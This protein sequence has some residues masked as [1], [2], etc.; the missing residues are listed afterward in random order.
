MMSTGCQDHDQ[1][2]VSKD[3]VIRFIQD[4]MCKAGTTLEDA[5]AVGHHLMTA[6]YRGHFS[7]GMNRMQMYVKN[8]ENRITDPAARPQ[9]V[10]DFQVRMGISRVNDG[11]T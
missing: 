2:V 8:I 4:C 7:H 10:T 3:E 6:D 1:K 9:I 11:G 5:Y